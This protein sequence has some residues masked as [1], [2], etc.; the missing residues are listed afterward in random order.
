[1]R[2]D[3][4]KD[5]VPIAPGEGTRE[6]LVSRR[7]WI[8]IATSSAAFAL[9]GVRAWPSRRA[10]APTPMTV[11]KSPSC[12]CC[13]KWIEHVRKA[14]FVVTERNLDDVTPIK[15]EHGVP[16]Q[17]YSCHTAVVGDYIVEGHVPADLVQR[18]L[19]ERPAFRGLA[20]PG[21][22]QSAPGMDIGHEKYDV[23]S[24]TRDGKTKVYAT[25]S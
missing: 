16:E 19:R 13:G 21:M 5:L 12:G 14:G 11:Y 3:K 20:A 7:T 22:P 1:V 23:I 2:R 10:V 15:R 4:E 17:L 9:M 6:S 18:M 25:R 8:G 24:F